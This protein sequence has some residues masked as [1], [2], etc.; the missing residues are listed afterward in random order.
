MATGIDITVDDTDRIFFL[1]T[2]VDEAL[3][4]IN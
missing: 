2:Y 4:G 1:K 3:K